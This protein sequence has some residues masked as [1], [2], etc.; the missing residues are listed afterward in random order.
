MNLSLVIDQ[1]LGLSICL[2]VVQ[3]KTS[4]TKYKRMAVT[5]VMRN[6]AVQE[7]QP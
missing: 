5:A 4:E 3:E 6:D 7:G 2:R 1:G